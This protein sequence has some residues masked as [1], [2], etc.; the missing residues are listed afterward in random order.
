[1]RSHSSTLVEYESMSGY[2]I[3][4]TLV[5]YKCPVFTTQRTPESPSHRISIESKSDSSID[6]I[7]I[8]IEISCDRNADGIGN[9]D[10]LEVSRQPET[11]DNILKCT[12]TQIF[13]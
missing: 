11:S 10:R 7:A 1:M 8:E 5:I 9:S 6:R 4:I 12:S 3:G 13:I 2:R